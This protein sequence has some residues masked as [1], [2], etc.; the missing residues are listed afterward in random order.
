MKLR[1]FYSVLIGVVLVLLLVGGIGAVWLAT[2]SK[3]AAPAIAAQPTQRLQK[4]SSALTRP[5]SV[6]C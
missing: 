1:S 4:P 2:G 3:D 5:V 6:Y